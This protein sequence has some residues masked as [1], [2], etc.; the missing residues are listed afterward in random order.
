MN[1]KKHIP[2]SLTLLNLLSG[3]LCVLFIIV[4]KHQW[5]PFAIGFSL[6]A[7][8]LDGLVARALGV[9]S[10]IGKELDSLADMVSFGLVPG[11]LLLAI[12]VQ[13]IGNIELSFL[14][15]F[16]QQL[17]FFDYVPLF[18]P[19]LIPLFAA[20]RLAKFNITEST[21]NDFVGL[22][23][24]AA[25][26]F[27]LGWYLNYYYPAITLSF[28]YQPLTI[29]IVS[30]LTAIAMVMPLPLFSFKLK[31]KAW[32]TIQW[33]LYLLIGAVPFIIFFHFFGLVLI[34]VWYIILNL[35]RKQP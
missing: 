3:S 24:P 14:S 6:L 21:S 27:V 7:D 11:F 23:T 31:N 12:Q 26:L 15:L 32:K 16:E 25:T 2:N 29:A 28:L 1:I 33:P 20:L 13:L 30:V 18:A 8:F 19:L 17:R 5:V 35:V 9:S 4:G 10:P 22:A 34:I